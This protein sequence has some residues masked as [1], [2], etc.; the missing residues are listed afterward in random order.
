MN[1]LL[2]GAILTA[3]VGGL[4]LLV[5]A[6]PSTRL[7]AVIYSVPIPMSILS[8]IGPELVEPNVILGLIVN[9]S[10][11]WIVAAGDR[12]RL[13][14]WF[15]TLI[16]TVGYVGSSWL[17]A[18]YF[19][20]SLLVA[21]GLALV[22]WIGLQPVIKRVPAYRVSEVAPIGPRRLIIVFLTATGAVSIASILGPFVVTFPY[23]GITMALTY[24]GSTVPFARSFWLNGMPALLAYGVGLVTASTAGLAMWAAVLCGLGC[25][26]LATGAA[27]LVQRPRGTAPTPE[28]I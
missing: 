25:W 2:V 17:L 3:Y 21:I 27:A 16:A 4:S 22:I 6:V 8:L 9:A 14:R 10:F 12:L 15:A 24:P 23:T 13:P 28:S 26:C 19:S 20:P 7:R 1:P 5:G 18:H 11:F